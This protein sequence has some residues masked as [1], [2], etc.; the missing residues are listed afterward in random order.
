MV[1][2]L[3]ARGW[4][5]AVLSLTVLLSTGASL[6][7]EIALRIT[8]NADP[9]ESDGVGPYCS[10]GETHWL[11]I[12]DLDDD[13]GLVGDF[14]VDSLRFPVHATSSSGLQPL[15]VNTWCWRPSLPLGY[16][17]F[18]LQDS[19]TFKQPD[20][21]G[22]FFRHAVGGCC[23]ADHEDLVIEIATAPC[24]SADDDCM[25]ALGQDTDHYAFPPWYTWAEP[26][27]IFDDEWFPS[28]VLELPSDI[29]I[30]VYGTG[31][32]PTIGRAPD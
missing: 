8:Q 4:V 27:G 22:E 29:I 5:V 3:G 18:D 23:D 1:Q 30:V 17:S 9:T 13:H 24:P 31:I 14:C 11:R 28:S 32:Q 12:F 6:Q 19:I 15:T 2:R 16:D 25:M 10:L 20:A 21:D 7:P 26:C